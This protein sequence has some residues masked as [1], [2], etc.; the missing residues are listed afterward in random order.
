L[1]VFSRAR[2]TR[3]KLIVGATAALAAPAIIRPRLLLAKAPP[4]VRAR[5]SRGWVKP[6][7][8]PHIDWSHPL[9][10][11]LEFY[12]FDTGAGTI[13]DLVKAR[14]VSFPCTNGAVAPRPFIGGQGFKYD[15]VSGTG[16]F[17]S[18]G[19]IQAVTAAPPW[20]VACGLVE[21]ATPAN[22]V[23][24][25]RT[26][27]NNASAPFLNW[28][29]QLGATGQTQWEFALNSGG[30]ITQIGNAVNPANGVWESMVGVAASA[31]VARF[32]FNGKQQGDLQYAGQG[33]CQGR[34]GIR[35]EQGVLAVAHR[36]RPFH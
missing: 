14:T 13:L 10:Q 35:L 11:N 21:N 28:G 6:A 29:F 20:T 32:F 19:R 22:G 3:R 36:A 31:S 16:V 26:A 12:G 24:F 33:T 18:D 34:A 27:N 9:A 15:G 4:L 23:P 25:C 17:T 5:A 8:I 1:S 2:L 30:T 7:S